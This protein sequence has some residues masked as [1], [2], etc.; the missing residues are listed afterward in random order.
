MPK[1]VIAETDLTLNLIAEV[2]AQDGLQ[3]EV[4]TCAM[5]NLMLDDSS[6]VSGPNTIS[7]F[8]AVHYNRIGLSEIEKAE[9]Q[10]W[11]SLTSHLSNS[12]YQE[13]GHQD[14][15]DFLTQLNTHL[16]QQT[17]IVG[18]DYT[19]ADIVAYTRLHSLLQNWA[20][21]QRCEY[22]HITRWFDLIQH[23]PSIEAAKVLSPI[24]IDLHFDKTFTPK[25]FKGAP[26]ETTLKD[27]KRA[28]PGQPAPTPISVTKAPQEKQQKEKHKKEK[29]EKPTG[30]RSEGSKAQDA[31]P[32]PSMISFKVGFIEKAVLHPDAD[33]LYVSTVNLGEDEPRQVVSGLVK[34]IP[35]EMMQERLVVCICNLK[36]VTM[37]GVKSSAMVLAGSPGGE[38]VAKDIVELVIP[39]EG[40]KAGDTLH[41]EGFE[42]IPEAQLNPK[43]KIFEAVQPGFTSTDELTVVYKTGDG[44]ISK[45]VDSRGGMCKLDSL[46][47]AS[48]R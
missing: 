5:S 24:S 3:T 2:F 46:K 42:G 37:R 39:P 1:L 8:F 30:G 43:K 38:G 9:V 28:N 14:S 22:C 15:D 17:Y 13:T 25:L 36:P 47:A 16:A 18:D 29:S 19:V 21:R 44:K 6:N 23:I 4:C 33:S 7:T 26:K 32:T 45:L 31:P 41:F 11:L 10:Q 40:A 20:K 34:Y 27:A 12:S 35:L 48:I